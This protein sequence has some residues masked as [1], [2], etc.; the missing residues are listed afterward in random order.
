M[1]DI[2][3]GSELWDFRLVDPDNRG[4]V[5]F[6]ARKK[7]L[8]ESRRLTLAAVL[9]RS[10]EGLPNCGSSS[11]RW[12]FAKRIRTFSTKPRYEPLSAEGTKAQHVVA[13]TRRRGGVVVPRLIMGLAGN[14]E[15]TSLASFR[16]ASGV[17]SWLT[18]ACFKVA[19]NLADLLETISGSIAGALTRLTVLFGQNVPQLRSSCQFA[20]LRFGKLGKVCRQCRPL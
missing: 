4:P 10:D 8:E 5:D 9:A 18:T 7:L 19:K 20:T 2:Y 6:A 11:A 16:S 14:W 15:D 13:F 1:P 3:Q 17:I 12:R